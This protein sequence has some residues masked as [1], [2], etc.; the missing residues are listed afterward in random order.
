MNK[1]ILLILGMFLLIIIS[2]D[3]TKEEDVTLLKQ[4]EYY[5]NY[6]K[7]ELEKNGIK[8]TTYFKIP[9]E[10]VNFSNLNH[11]E[12]ISNIDKAI[13]LL[14]ENFEKDKRYRLKKIN[15]LIST[16]NGHGLIDKEGF[17]KKLI[18]ETSDDKR[19]DIYYEEMNTYFT[20]LDKAKDLG[21]YLLSNQIVKKYSYLTVLAKDNIGNFVSVNF[22]K[23]GEES[24][25]KFSIEKY[26]VDYQREQKNI[27]Q[28]LGNQTRVVVINDE[29]IK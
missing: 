12:I 7:K 27:N 6:L 1:S 16:I 23:A 8:N 18:S 17:Y 9:I 13:P 25:F 28:N 19:I 3:T 5:I 26:D 29:R 4:Q 14:K 10:D 21:D 2:C 20:E 24:K 11:Y 22:I 15:L